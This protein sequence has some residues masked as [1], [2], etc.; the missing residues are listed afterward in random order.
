[1]EFTKKEIEAAKTLYDKWTLKTNT[2]VTFQGFLNSLLKPETKFIDVRIELDE[3][4]GTVENLLNTLRVLNVISVTKLPEVFTRE[5][6]MEY[7]IFIFGHK[8]QE[9]KSIDKWLTERK[10]K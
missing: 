5:D 8:Y 1:M 10:S 7:G 9:Q 3:N 6:M 4:V 2:S